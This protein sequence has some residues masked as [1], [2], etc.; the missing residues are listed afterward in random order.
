[1]R[2]LKYVYETIFIEPKHRKYSIILYNGVTY[3]I[4]WNIGLTTETKTPN[5][6]KIEVYSFLKQL[7]A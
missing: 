3:Y 7:W 2:I 1:M 6:N 4:S 5:D